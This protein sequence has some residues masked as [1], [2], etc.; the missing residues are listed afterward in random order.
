[1]S[2]SKWPAIVD[3]LDKDTATARFHDLF[4][5]IDRL[6]FMAAVAIPS[7]AKCTEDGASFVGSITPEESL[8]KILSEISGLLDDAKKEV[9]I[10]E[11]DL[12]KK[13]EAN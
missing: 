7:W 4:T 12:S 2:E 10:L 9:S 6:W 8:R 3:Q 1:M 5:A 13:T 11:N